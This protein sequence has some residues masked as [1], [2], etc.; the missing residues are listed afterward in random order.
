MEKNNSTFDQLVK[1]LSSEETQALLN[2]IQAG[3]KGVK[4]ESLGSSEEP[5]FVKLKPKDAVAFSEEPFLLRLW[6]SLKA[7]LR[8]IPIE[9]LYGEQLLKRL[10]LY[11][12]KVAGD[13][14]VINKGIYTNK[15]Y[16]Y[17]KDL[18]KTQL[19]FSSVLSSYDS[20]KGHFY[21]LLSS[22]TTPLT[23]E[24]LMKETDPFSVT[25][26]GEVSPSM[27]TNF[28]RKID[29]IFANLT[30]SEKS[31]MY[32]SAQALEW[33]RAFCSLSLDKTLLQFSPAEGSDLVCPTLTIQS[34]VEILSAILTSRKAIPQNLL[35]AMFL[36]S[37]QEKMID[38]ND[39]LKAEADEFVKDAIQALQSVKKF[40]IAIP[41]V[42]ITR[43]IKKDINWQPYKIE[44][45]EDWFIYFKQAWYERFNQ[46][47]QKWSYEQKKYNLKIKM[48]N[49]LK[50]DDLETV[51]FSPWS[52]LWI[53]CI[54]KKE[55]AYSFLKTV[56]ANFYEEKLAT[57]L[58]IILVEGSFYK[59]EN[60][61]EYTT[62][63]NVLQHR[64]AEFYNYEK[65]LSPTGDIGLAFAKI[66]A[67]KTA[68]LKN[69]NKI[70][71]LMKT[72]DTEAKQIILST[73]ESLKSID[74]ILSGIIGG[75][76]SS[77]YASL[78][79]WTNIQGIK[80]A[81]FRESVLVVKEQ[82]HTIIDLYTVAE[83]L[84]TEIA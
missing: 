24:K 19:F 53:N 49:F 6:I 77:I 82:I 45:G 57:V 79:N 4:S 1:S 78:A 47:W 55:I 3:M 13:Y 64:K 68:S 27:R 16:E 12:K 63:Y 14:I 75:G 36:I 58:R 61:N 5:D 15:F 9:A 21:L 11:L 50:V 8:S 70:E 44:G 76:K 20:S 7:F 38:D 81:Q 25:I 80:N 67:E 69:K 37:S 26:A 40:Y 18:R 29:S 54:F 52:N 17:L 46:K 83:K 71:G 34:E 31:E 73:V 23:Y 22:F 32:K 72:V 28:L 59:R 65:R 39:R 62:S 56:L 60:L 41:I 35:K 2:S 33:M 30:D 43:Y 66:K 84:E 48:L 42:D 51:Q 74:I 10:S